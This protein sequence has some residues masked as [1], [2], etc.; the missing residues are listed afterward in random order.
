MYLL[1][2]LIIKEIINQFIELQRLHSDFSVLTYICRIIGVKDN[3]KA[4]ILAKN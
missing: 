4:L 2:W 3:A 1:D